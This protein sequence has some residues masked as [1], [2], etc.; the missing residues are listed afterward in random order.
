VIVGCG[1]IYNVLL[2]SLEFRRC[3][4]I[5]VFRDV[6]PYSLVNRCQRFGG[7]CGFHLQFGDF[8]PCSLF[9]KC[10]C[11]EGNDG[12]RLYPF[13]LKMEAVISCEM[14]TV[15]L[16]IKIRDVAC[17]QKVPLLAM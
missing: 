6:T 3:N 1:M 13:T 5:K 15:R 10:R 11:V 9:E 2:S 4:R 16:S 14:L 7:T 12:N 8:M 17:Q